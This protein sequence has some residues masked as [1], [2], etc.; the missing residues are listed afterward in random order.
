MGLYVGARVCNEC[1]DRA[2]GRGKDFVEGNWLA[3]TWYQLMEVPQHR[4]PVPRHPCGWIPL[5]VL[6]STRT[7]PAR[8]CG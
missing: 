4:V 1:S 3:D 2:H 7:M 6:I 5:L 8:C